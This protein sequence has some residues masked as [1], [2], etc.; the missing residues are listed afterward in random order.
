MSKHC[1]EELV[2]EQGLPTGKSKLVTGG[3]KDQDGSEH[4][5]ALPPMDA[6]QIDAQKEEVASQ[7]QIAYVDTEPDPVPDRDPN[8]TPT[9]GHQLSAPED[10]HV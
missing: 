6:E 2:I 9:R 8:T 1:A 5:P 7:D 10:I 4:E 3:D